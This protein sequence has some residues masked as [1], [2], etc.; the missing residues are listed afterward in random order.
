VLICGNCWGFFGLKKKKDFPGSGELIR[1]TVLLSLAVCLAACGGGGGG[2]SSSTSSGPTLEQVVAEFVQPQ[3]DRHRDRKIG[4]VVGTVGPVKGVVK[5]NIFYF[6]KLKDQ[7]GNPLPLNGGTEFEIGSVTKTFTATILASLLQGQPSL[8]DT[9]VGS[10]FSGTPSFGGEVPTI[11]ELANY[12]SGLPDTNRGS[13]SG[14]CTFSGGTITTCYDMTLL[15]ENLS[16][17]ALTALLF[18]PGTEYLYSDLG[19]ALLALAEP[20]LNGSTA[21]DPLTLLLEWEGLLGSIVLQPLGMNST[22]AFDPVN[23]PALL[24]LGYRLESSGKIDI[25]LG[26]NTSWPAFIG[27]GGIV[28]TPDDMMIYLKYNLGLLA[29]PLNTLLPTLHTPSTTVTTKDG[30]QI[31]LAWFLGTLKGS[32]IP[33]ISKN[34]EVP[35]F[36]AQVDFAP[37]TNTGVFVVTNAAADPEETPIVDVQLTAYKVLQILNGLLPTGGGPSGDQP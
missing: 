24:P 23:D 34:G 30:E 19:F 32:S 31:A 18:A 28:S 36:S 13:G 7:V 17:P 6:G 3:L 15:L 8:I 22:H 1:R 29:T 2:G 33:F 14:S 11:G 20:I 4:V 9:S 5:T 26:H 12:N 27:A 10:I 16:N 35:A 37:S 25:G 21:T